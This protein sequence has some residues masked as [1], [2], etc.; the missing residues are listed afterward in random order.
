M[1]LAAENSGQGMPLVLIHAFPLSSRMWKPQVKILELVSQVILLDLPGFGRSPSEVKP[2]MASMARGS[3]SC[4]R[5]WLALSM[6]WP[7]SRR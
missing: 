2:S 6:T 5:T 7:S 3:A 1:S 4:C